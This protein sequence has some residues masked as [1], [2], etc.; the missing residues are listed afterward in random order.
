MTDRTAHISA[1][2]ALAALNHI[3]AYT[4]DFNEQRGILAQFIVEASQLT[5]E[6]DEAIKKFGQLRESLKGASQACSASEAR[7]T[8][9]ESQ[10]AAL[11]EAAK[12][13]VDCDPMTWDPGNAQA[14]EECE[15]ALGN[16]RQALK[17]IE[18]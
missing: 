4:I 18:R 1:A 11:R 10:L 14:M 7:A 2:D 9:A 5:A 13:L 8:A 6:R 12:R 3:S 17:A 15:T 16:L